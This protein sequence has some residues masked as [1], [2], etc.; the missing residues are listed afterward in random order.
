MSIGLHEHRQRRAAVISRA[1]MCGRMPRTIVSTSGSS[2]TVFSPQ[3]VDFC[4]KSGELNRKLRLQQN[5]L[6][7][8]ESVLRFTGSVSV[9]WTLAPSRD[10]QTH[11]TDCLCSVDRSS[12]ENWGLSDFPKCA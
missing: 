2:G 10:R 12:P 8:S 4:S 7:N 3:L 1:S 5:H 11:S 6:L 9:V